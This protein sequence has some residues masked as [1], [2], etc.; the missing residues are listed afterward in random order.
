MLKK[1]DVIKYSREKLALKTKEIPETVM[2]VSVPAFRT[3]IYG[4]EDEGKVE[5]TQAFDHAR[6]I[7]QAKG[8]K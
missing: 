8:T 3:R 1:T 6:A 4:S 2:K 7:N 5:R